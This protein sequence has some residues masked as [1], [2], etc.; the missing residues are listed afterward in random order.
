MHGGEGSPVFRHHDRVRGDVKRSSIDF[1][2]FVNDV[3]RKVGNSTM[4]H[5]FL[6]KGFKTSNDSVSEFMPQSQVPQGRACAFAN[7]PYVSERIPI[8]QAGLVTLFPHPQRL[9][10]YARTCIKKVACITSSLNAI[11]GVSRFSS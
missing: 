5:M 6:G 9:P 2:S 4:V 3:A 1:F 10:T 8:Y 11:F 7:M